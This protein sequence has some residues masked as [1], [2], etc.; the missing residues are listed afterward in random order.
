MDTYYPSF[1]CCAALIGLSA[2]ARA[3]RLA[4]WVEAG[5]FALGGC[6]AVYLLALWVY[7]IYPQWATPVW[8]LTVAGMS[9]LAGVRG[10]PWSR[11]I[12][13]AL[14]GIVAGWTVLRV[15]EEHPFAVWH[16]LPS[17]WLLSAGCGWG[18]AAACERP[19]ERLVA[20]GGLALGG[21]TQTWVGLAMAGEGWAAAG[22]A[23]AL[24]CNVTWLTAALVLGW[25]VLACWRREMTGGRPRPSI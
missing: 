19:R 20:L 6:G 3:E 25:T 16:G 10:V 4:A 7:F 13:A 9:A 15:W 18:I 17:L 12:R 21:S 8:G 1:V 24:I 5:R 2:L 23:S 14:I 22:N 11:R